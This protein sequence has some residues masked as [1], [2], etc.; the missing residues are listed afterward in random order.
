MTQ[1][2]IALLIPF[3]T[4][5]FA[6]L[7]RLLFP[8]RT[9]N[10]VFGQLSNSSYWSR[11]QPVTPPVAGDDSAICTRVFGLALV[12]LSVILGIKVL[13]ELGM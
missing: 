2:L 6:G 4:F 7:P 3:V 12:R 1:Y 5:M 9:L 8:Q 11:S 13:H 10:F